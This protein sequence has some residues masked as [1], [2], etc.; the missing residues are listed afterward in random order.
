MAGKYFDKMNHFTRF[1]CETA[2]YDHMKTSYSRLRLGK[3]RK[4]SSTLPLIPSFTV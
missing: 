4:Y 1:A 3:E 2:P